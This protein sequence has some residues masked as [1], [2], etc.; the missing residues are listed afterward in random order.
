MMRFIAIAILLLSATALQAQKPQTPRQP[1][2]IVNGQPAADLRDVQPED[3]V[4]TEVLPADEE[5]IGRYGEQ[6]NYGVII[7]SLRYDTPARFVEGGGES[8]SSY[9]A[10]HVEWGEL[11]RV[12]RYVA[13]FT[14]REDG[15]I[16]V[17]KDLESTDPRLRRKVLRAVAKSPRWQPAT[18]DGRPVESSHVLR[19]QLPEGREMPPERAVILL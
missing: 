18:K 7:I 13:R 15:S 1:L 16:A 5:T 4:S 8:F 11:E 19:I 14:V 2:Y 10:H 12:A 6:A 9:I 17:E 3:I